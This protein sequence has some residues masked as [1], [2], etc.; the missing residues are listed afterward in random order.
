[1]S[2]CRY[3]IGG[4]RTYDDVSAI[5]RDDGYLSCKRRQEKTEGEDDVRYE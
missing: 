1:M 3:R 2:G 5:V 4:W